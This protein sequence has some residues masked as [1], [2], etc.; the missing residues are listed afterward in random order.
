MGCRFVVLL[1]YFRGFGGLACLILLCYWLIAG[2]CCFLLLAIIASGCGF[3]M[4]CGG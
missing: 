3:A 2:V 1:D 4:P